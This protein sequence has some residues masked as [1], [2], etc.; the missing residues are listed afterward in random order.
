MP[1]VFEQSLFLFKTYG[2]CK[3]TVHGTSWTGFPLFNYNFNAQT[4]GIKKM[5]REILD[6]CCYYDAFFPFPSFPGHAKDGPDRLPA[7]DHE[8]SALIKRY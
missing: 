2:T 3:K 8:I 1:Q 4:Y 7:A 5:V 6:A